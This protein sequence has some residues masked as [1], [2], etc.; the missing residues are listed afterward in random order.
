MRYGFDIV[1]NPAVPAH[2]IAHAPNEIHNAVL[3][4]MIIPRTTAK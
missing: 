2:A 4:P 3:S 1:L